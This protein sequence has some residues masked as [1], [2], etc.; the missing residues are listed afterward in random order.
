[1][2]LSWI[3]SKA[4][5]DGT[6]NN[7]LG[8]ALRLGSD[9]NVPSVRATVRQSY[10]RVILDTKTAIPLL[11]DY[12]QHVLRPSKAAAYGLLAR[13]YLSMRKY[14]S[15]FKYSDLCIRL[16]NELMN[17]NVQGG[18]VIDITAPVTFKRYNAETIFFSQINLQTL[19]HPDLGKIDTVLYAMYDSNDLRK[20]AFFTPDPG[21]RYQKFK[22]NYTRAKDFFFTGIA[23]DEMYLTR[24]ECYAR[25]NNKD[26]ALADLNKLL[27]NRWQTGTFADITATDAQ[28]ALNKILVERRKELLMRG[29]RWIDI[30]RLN[31]EPGPGIF[32]NRVMHGQTYTLQ[33]NAGYYALPLPTDIINL[34]AMPQNPY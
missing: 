24:A 9:F 2:N 22:G 10:D 32:L 7:D 14:D 1:L 31:K 12:P 23:T 17:Y 19:A 28:D 21:S 4:F 33:P 29:L 30:K 8:I 25:L 15:A 18:D 16:K 11:P 13:A 6:A 5:D 20:K 26:S 27:R 34:T 3:F